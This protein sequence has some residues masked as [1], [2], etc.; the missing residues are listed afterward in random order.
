[1]NNTYTLTLGS[2]PLVVS[3]PHVGIHIPDELKERYVPRALQVEDT[4]WH[5]PLLYGFAKAMGATVL[6]GKVS[7]Y[8]IDL[9]R[10]PD[11]AP[12]YPGASNT[13][14]C[15]T[16]FFTGD[17]IYKEQQAPNEKEQALRLTRYWRPYHDCLKATLSEVKEKH[18]H[19]VLWDAHSIRQEIPWLFEGRLAGL[20]L[21]TAD[22]K[23]CATSLRQKLAAVLEQSQALAP[24]FT[25]IVDGRFKGGYTTRHY[26]NPAHGIHVAQMEMAQ[27]LYMDET[28]PFAYNEK[29]ASKVQP[30]LKALLSTMQNWAPE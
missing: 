1:V 15:P 25:S 28:Y 29:L 23:S 7:R 12:M 8:V 22:A 10:P 4:D 14:L 19:V 5:L 24:E 2:S 27:A 16:R 20:N 21:G 13:E 18:G 30:V 26:G 6:Q 11:N 9:N 3:M 17:P